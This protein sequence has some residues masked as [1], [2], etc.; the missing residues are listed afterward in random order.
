LTRR[1]R[2]PALARRVELLA[3]AA[4]V[5][6]CRQ[7]RPVSDRAASSASCGAEARRV[8]E[9][10]G[11]RERLVSLLAPDSILRRELTDAYRDLV[12]PS[13]LA[14]WQD[15]PR[16]APGRETSN[17]WPAR[18]DVA[19]VQ[20]DSSG[21]R[22]EG[23]VVDVATSD[24]ASPVDRR[25]VSVHLVNQGGWRVSAYESARPGRVI[26]ASG[27]AADTPADSAPTDVV[28][29]YYAAIQARDYDAA[30]ALWGNGGE[31]SG[32]SRRDFAAGFAE[33]ARVTVTIADSVSI[34]AAAGSQYATVP[35]R[36]D[37]VLRDGS[38]QHFTGSYILRRSMVDGATAEQRRW[39]IYKAS[40]RQRPA[41]S[42]S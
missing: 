24:T 18:I 10:L 4:L 19:S 40:L 15:R 20:A 35:V 39:T 13:L 41:Q 12:T 21:C 32:K 22:V 23:D 11:R 42:T 1:H 31:A 6:G 38:E 25:H 27:A 17:P 26:G 8:V 34:G 36:V 2:A 3:A 9:E 16:N 33:T 14:A 7:G 5:V 37:A 29:R 28:R 30:Y